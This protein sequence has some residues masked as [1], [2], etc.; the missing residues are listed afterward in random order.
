MSQ[1]LSCG[2]AEKPRVK[3]A[4]P[5]NPADTAPSVP[6]QSGSMRIPSAGF[7]DKRLFKIGAAQRLFDQRQPRRL[8]GGGKFLAQ[9]KITHDRA[10]CRNRGRLFAHV[11][12]AER[13]N[14]ISAAFS[15]AIPCFRLVLPV[16][17]AFA[18]LGKFPVEDSACHKIAQQL[19]RAAADGE[20]A[21]VAHHALQR[22]LA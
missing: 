8:I 15:W 19:R 14:K 2:P 16:G 22:K 11:N 4:A 6:V 13:R 10:Q 3:G 7:R 18:F 9:R 5:G 1:G 17:I 12:V 21:G 20:H